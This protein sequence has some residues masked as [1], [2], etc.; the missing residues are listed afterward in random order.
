MKQKKKRYGYHENGRTKFVELLKTVTKN[1][2][3]FWSKESKTCFTPG[4]NIC[5]DVTYKNEKIYSGF[6]QDFFNKHNYTEPKISK[7]YVKGKLN[8]K[9]EEYHSP[10][11]LKRSGSYLNNELD[12]SIKIF[13]K[14][15]ECLS[16]IDYKKGVKHG[17]ELYFKNDDGFVLRYYEN[18]NGKKHGTSKIFYNTFFHEID[19]KNGIKKIERIVDSNKENVICEL[20]FVRSKA[21]EGTQFSY[22]FEENGSYKYRKANFIISKYSKGKKHGAEFK[23]PVIDSQNHSVDPKK[24]L[25]PDSIEFDMLRTWKN[26]LLDG[27]YIINRFDSSFKKTRIEEKGIYKNGLKTKYTHFKYNNKGMLVSEETFEKD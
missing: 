2:K 1:K 17:E 24:F 26:G 15:G 6:Y 3:T 22:V 19:Y 18:K 10:G 8:G 12:G 4:G 7:Y 20:K 25:N 5:F 9:F 11:I 13:N 23:V 16:A 27:L 21:H 14:K